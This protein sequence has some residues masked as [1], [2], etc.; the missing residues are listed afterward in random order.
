MAATILPQLTLAG[1]VIAVTAVIHAVFIV[2]VRDWLRLS[3]P[4]PGVI[5]EIVSVIKLT[6]ISL[7][8]IAAHVMSAGV[9]A[10]VYLRT[11][12]SEDFEAALYFALSTYT[13]LGFGDV[14][15]PR[16]WELL[17]GFA[18][19]NGL[20]MF[21]LTAAVLVDAAARLRTPRR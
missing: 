21:G 3:E 13:T 11:G 18:S 19:L 14:L 1:G 7:W 8:L 6:F 15:A 16:E 17:T 2:M 10:L 20:L 12:T 5:D 9:W 4:R